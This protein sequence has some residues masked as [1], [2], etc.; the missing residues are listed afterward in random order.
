MF[1][2]W[3]KQIPDWQ[4]LVAII[5]YLLLLLLPDKLSAAGNIDLASVLAP[6]T[7]R[8]LQYH[9]L[10]PL[11]YRELLRRGLEINLDPS[12]LQH[13]RND[14][15][16]AL[17]EAARQ[18]QE[19]FKIIRALNG[20][21]IEFILLKGA[22][23]R[24]RLYGDSAVRPMADVDLL[25]SLDQVSHVNPIL[26]EL[27]L[28]LQPQCADPRP[29]FRELFRNELHFSPP[30]GGSL[31]VD[32][33]WHLTGMAN[34]YTLPFSRL[35]KMASSW[36]YCGQPV[37]VLC[38]EHA[39]INLALHALDELHGAMQIID[40]CLALYTMPLHWPTLRQEVTHLR[41]QLPVYLVLGELAQ[42]LP[43]IVP[44]TVLEGLAAYTP[45]WAENLALHHSLGY[46]TPH[47]AVLYRQH[48]LRDRLFYV[49]ALL[50]PGADY[51]NAVY[52]QPDRVRFLRQFVR[53]LFSS[54]HSWRP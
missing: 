10:T 51:L 50:W 32:L 13:L 2:I 34:F 48:R 38:P 40:L 42:L 1:G 11:L 36:S 23:L 19:I 53:T 3:Q 25:V 49:A 35:Q 18:D 9:S 24:M 4:Q 6:S 28:K 26:K 30:Q 16:L 20:A 33:H 7:L 39:V 29:G 21:G 41:C 14:Y 54:T 46:L 5:K 45:S 31:V 52:G 8:L 12:I 17:K 27:G 15:I 44:S 22:D 37:K 43:G 47:F